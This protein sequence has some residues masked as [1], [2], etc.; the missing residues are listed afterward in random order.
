M[1]RKVG[2]QKKYRLEPKE[3]LF[4]LE[5]KLPVTGVNTWRYDAAG[6]PCSWYKF[7]KIT[8]SSCAPTIWR[9]HK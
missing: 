6:S 1:G 2:Q 4:K 9:I 7:K 8:L 3:E 5:Q